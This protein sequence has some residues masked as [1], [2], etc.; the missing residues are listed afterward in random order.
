MSSPFAGYWKLYGRENAEVLANA[1]PMSN[2]FKCA[3]KSVRTCEEIHVNGD[4]VH[5]NIHVPEYTI[6]AHSKEINFT[7]GE[8]TCQSLPFGATGK[9]T[10]VKESDTKWVAKL[11][12]EKGSCTIV[13]E[14]RNGEM[15]VTVE[16][17]HGV[18]MVRKFERHVESCGVASTTCTK[19]CASPFQGCWRLYGSQNYDKYMEVIGVPAHWR[20]IFSNLCVKESIHVNGEDVHIK[21]CLPD[22]HVKPHI[23]EVSFKF[24]EARELA[25]PFGHHALGNPHKVSETKWE[26]TLSNSEKLGNAKLTCEIVNDELWHTIETKGKHFVQKFE[27]ARCGSADSTWSCSSA[28]NTC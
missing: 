25:L 3:M 16:G 10:V 26:T 18:K 28:K 13:R 8:E 14:I 6:P 17:C 7:F 23:H 1:I 9:G 19:E 11:T 22:V 20:C 27:R 12:H 15:W 21:I 4:N 2:Q 24:G 5:V